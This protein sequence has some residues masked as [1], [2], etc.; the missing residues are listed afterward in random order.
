LQG[1]GYTPGR[2]WVPYQ[3]GQYSDAYSANVG[4][5]SGRGLG[6]SSYYLRA[7]GDLNDSYTEQKSDMDTAKTQFSNT[8]DNS[9]AN[10]RSTTALGINT[11]LMDAVA[12][13]AAQYGVDTGSVGTGKE[14]VTYRRR[15][16][17]GATSEQR[18]PQV[19]PK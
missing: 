8:A 13:L 2:G 14:G 6:Q 15:T 12:R 4:D 18:R 5:F 3:Q 19:K 7:L 9:L 1:L 11:E 17:S 10:F 16:D